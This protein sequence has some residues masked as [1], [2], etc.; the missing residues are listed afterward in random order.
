MSNDQRIPASL[1]DLLK[2][3]LLDSSH[4][5]AIDIISNNILYRISIP[6]K[7]AID[8]W[9]KLRHGVGLSGYWPI[10]IGGGDSI[11]DIFEMLEEED[12]YD[13]EV[14]IKKAAAINIQAW[15]ND[16]MEDEEYSDMPEVPHGP[17]PDNVRPSS[18]FT[19]HTEILS[20]NPHET[21]DIVF[22]PTTRPWEAAAYFN[23]GTWNECPN[24]DVHVAFAQSW[25]ERYGAEPIGFTNS[26][27]EFIVE[28]PPVTKD[29]A[30][31]LALEKYAYCY[32]IV[33]QGTETI[34][35]L[36]AVLLNGTSWYFWWD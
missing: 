3:N 2:M 20:G 12:N 29:D 21:V 18:E 13:P 35:R 31:A 26:T 7:Y 34:E 14:T 9:K 24:S 22:I 4:L 23:Y 15:I 1:L 27:I 17:W 28:R 16:A 8:I 19:V 33:E 11:N 25:Y 5:E 30:L 6:G 10:I 36:A 32:D